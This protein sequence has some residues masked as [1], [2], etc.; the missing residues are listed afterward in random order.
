MSTAAPTRRWLTNA[1]TDPAEKLDACIKR[2]ADLI[3][4]L[5]GLIDDLNAVTE[6]PED[7]LSEDELH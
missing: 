6:D 1:S 2:L 4:R 3:E 5:D 7:D